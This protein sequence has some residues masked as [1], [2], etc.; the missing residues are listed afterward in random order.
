[1][2]E[3]STPLSRY[4]GVVRGGLKDQLKSA[5]RMWKSHE[6]GNQEEAFY[7]GKVYGLIEGLRYAG[8][9]NQLP[10]LEGLLSEYSV[11]HHELLDSD[12]VMS[13]VDQI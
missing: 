1:M 7:E 4:R 12:E 11:H 5:L 10:I 3:D 6:Q 9:G 2:I 13:I 8:F